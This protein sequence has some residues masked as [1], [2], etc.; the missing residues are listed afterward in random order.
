MTVS[1][2]D[3]SEVFYAQVLGF[4]RR[5]EATLAG[6]AHARVEGMPGARTRRERL[7]LGAECVE[8]SEPIGGVRRAIPADS[9]SNDRWFQHVAIVA[10]DMDRAYA[11]LEEHHVGH[12]SPTPQTLPAWNRDAAGIRA[13]YFKDPDLHTL[14]V[15][16]FPP[17]K[18]QPRWH[19]RPRDAPGD[20]GPADDLFL[21]IDHTAIAVADS[22]ASR[23]FYLGL[24][25]HVA[26]ET[27][28]WGPEQERLNAV[29]GAH[30]RITSLR[31]ESG[32]GIELLEYLW[33]RTG[34]AIPADQR[35]DDLAH[36]RT[37]LFSQHVGAPFPLRDPDGHLLEVHSLHEAASEGDRTTAP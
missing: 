32:P 2:L 19:G 23:S 12:A 3:R 20:P 22:A 33:P 16:W 13:Y 24:G 37:V 10:R 31:S 15:I 34:R 26:G 36:W 8:L 11:W 17:G 14:E 7:D 35:A 6:E 30:L 25:L 5:G 21:G 18:G 28:N 29:P 4:H 9:R 27:E 1:D